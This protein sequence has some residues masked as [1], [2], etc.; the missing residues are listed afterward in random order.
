[1]QAQMQVDVCIAPPNIV[2]VDGSHGMNITL[3]D[4]VDDPI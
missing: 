4:I 2:G 3:P 1:M